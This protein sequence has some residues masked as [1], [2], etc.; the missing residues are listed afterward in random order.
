LSRKAQRRIHDE[1]PPERRR[2]VAPARLELT[3]HTLS[4]IIITLVITTVASLVKSR[5]N[6]DR[7]VSEQSATD[8]ARGA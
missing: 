3:V 5:Y 8:R 6:H 2:L 4:V 7:D 1:A